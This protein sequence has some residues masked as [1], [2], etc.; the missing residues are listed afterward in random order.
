MPVGRTPTAFDARATLRRDG[1]PGHRDPAGDTQAD[2]LPR[3]ELL[4][5]RG[6]RSNNI[7]RESGIRL[8]RARRVF[9]SFSALPSLARPPLDLRPRRR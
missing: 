8:R 2:W 1:R 9:A 4:L 6:R 5:R 7:G 3:P